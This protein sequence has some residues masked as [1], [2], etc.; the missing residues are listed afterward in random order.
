MEDNRI[1]EEE[2]DRYLNGLMA[3]SEKKAFDLKLAEDAELRKEVDLQRAIIKAV[4]KEQLEKILHRE[5]KEIKKRS[6][7]KFVIPFASL[8]IAASMAGFFYI[9][10]LNNCEGVYN[11]Y[12]ESYTYTPV[13]SRGDEKVT[14]TK[15][16][17]IFFQALHHLESDQKK[18]AINELEKLNNSSSEMIAAT[19]D[20]V[21]WYLS[22]AYIKNGQKEKAKILLQE[23]AKND[24]SEYKTKAIVLLKD[25]E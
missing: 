22:L 3:D 18:L 12:Y 23:I 14:L 15:S 19:N 6:I 5:E 4:R 17:S 13:P 10:F 7:R 21:K 24:I 8:A 11:R 2:I 9:G 1:M 16:D 25:L 20:A